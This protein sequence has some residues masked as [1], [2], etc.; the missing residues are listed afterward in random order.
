MIIAEKNTQASV[1]QELYAPKM[2]KQ[3]AYLELLDTRVGENS[4]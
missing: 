3:Q 4:K 2:S 1:V